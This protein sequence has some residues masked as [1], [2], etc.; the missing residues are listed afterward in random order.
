MPSWSVSRRPHAC[1]RQCASAALSSFLCSRVGNTVFRQEGRGRWLRK[2]RNSCDMNG[3]AANRNSGIPAQRSGSEE[4]DRGSIIY[5]WGRGWVFFVF[6]FCSIPKRFNTN[7]FSR[8]S[9]RNS[10]SLLVISNSCFL[11]FWLAYVAYTTWFVFIIINI[12]PNYRH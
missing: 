11:D 2:D 3:M 7:H 4:L 8:C 10:K 9:T 6:L 5:E 12:K 1:G